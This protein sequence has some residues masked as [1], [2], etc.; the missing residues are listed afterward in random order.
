MKSER[1]DHYGI[2][3]ARLSASMSKDPSKQVGACVLRPDGSI[4]TKGW[5]GFP[6]GCDDN[7]E[8]YS[9]KSRKLMR[10]VHAEANAIV[11]AYAPLHGCTIYVTP[12]Q[13]CSSCA[14]LIIQS[15]ITRV[16]TDQI[17]H[18][19]RWEQEF[20][21]AKLMF[22]EAGVTLEFIDPAMVKSPI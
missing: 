21:E 3:E 2:R 20:A 9:D 6:R 13:P 4:A 22:D 7:P 5:N 1:W 16:V 14:G 15:G 10:T 11:S 19:K 17:N 18:S 8:I 12:M